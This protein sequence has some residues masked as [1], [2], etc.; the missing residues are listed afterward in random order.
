MESESQQPSTGGDLPLLPARMVNEFAYCPRLA[1]FEWVDG[2]FADNAETME[3]RFHHRRVDQAPARKPRQG[4]ERKSEETTI[5]Q[6]S[7]WLSSERL[8][9]TAKIDLVEGEGPTVVPVDYKRGKRPHTPQGAWEPERVQLCVQGL[10]LREQGFVCERGVLY[11]VASRERVEVPFDEELVARTHELLHDMRAMAG[12]TVAP[13]PLV[14]SPKCPR[15]SLVGLCLPDEV[16]WLREPHEGEAPALRKLVPGNDDALPLHVQT[17]GARLS[18]D[19]ECL[20][21][22]DHDAVIGEARLIETSQV[23]LYGSVQA[24]TQVI[25]ELCKRNIPLVYCSSGGWFYGITIGLPHKHIDLRRRQY[26][27]AADSER[28]LVLARRFVQAKIANCRTLLRRNHR[29]AP[30]TIIID[31]K[32]DQVQA[33]AVNSLETLLGIE[34]TAARRYFSEFAGMLKE[35]EPCARFD[36]DGRNRRPPRDP[37]NAMLSLLYSILAREWTVTLHSVGLDPYLGFYHQPRY[38]R[39]ALALD[40]MEEFRPLIADSAVLTAINNGE[41]RQS[42]W[43]ERMGS[44]T[45]T[46]DGRRRLIETYERRMGQDITHPVFGYQISYRRVLEVQARLLGR[47][48]LGEIPEFPAFITR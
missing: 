8:G 48:L 32:R 13:P 6:R 11:F 14:D 17:P 1:Y 26:A 35:A 5:H 36:F 31:L 18:K 24:S 16:G 33:G 12:A 21:V 28:C 3:G 19:G 23:V 9:V 40:M 44:V 37:V 39:P 7:V 47:Y 45:L 15:C 42:D 46:P 2:E 25:Q 29:A 20:K 22:K 41:I 34:G 4:D 10:L 43:F 30:E 38:G 27:V